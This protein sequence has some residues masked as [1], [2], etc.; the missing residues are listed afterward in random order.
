MLCHLCSWADSSPDATLAS[1]TTRSLSQP[2]KDEPEQVVPRVSE[3]RASSPVDESGAIRARNASREAGSLWPMA[4]TDL[5][6]PRLESEDFRDRADTRP[7]PGGFEAV[8]GHLSGM[9][10]EGRLLGASPARFGARL[11]IAVVSVALLAPH[12]SPASDRLAPHMA[13]LDLRL[14]ED[15]FADAER[16]LGPAEVK[17]NSGEAAA[18]ALAACYVGS[19]GTTLALISTGGF[20]GGRLTMYQ[21][22][23]RVTLANFSGDFGGD[24]VVPLAK[25]PRCA[26][27]AKLSHKTPTLGGLRLGMR[28]DEVLRLLG[29]PCDKAEASLGFCSE[30]ALHPTADEVKRLKKQAGQGDYTTLHVSRWLIVEFEHGKVVA[31]RAEQNES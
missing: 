11:R 17:E 21:L 19:D 5:R 23:A 22:V 15:T 26:R 31:I 27:S 4:S 12:A 9:A 7:A 24:Y 20:R 18:S 30:E 2:D 1:S 8:G 6:K 28:S 29:N 14:S 3:E 25:R 16:L 10:R 13:I